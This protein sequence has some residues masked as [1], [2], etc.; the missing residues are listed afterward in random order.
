MAIIIKGDKTVSENYQLS[1]K[2]KMLG[3][4]LFARHVKKENALAIMMVL[5][6]DDQIDDFTWYMGEHPTAMDEELVSVAYQIVK[7]SQGN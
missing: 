5:E 4:A 6:N 1:E 3:G 7:D 2:Q